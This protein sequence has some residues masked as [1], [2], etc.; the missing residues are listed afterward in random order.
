MSALHSL[1]E[2]FAAAVFAASPVDDLLDSVD[3]R[4]PVKANAG[5]G[6]YRRSVI[7]NLAAAVKTSYPVVGAIVGEEFMTAACRRYAQAFPSTSGDLNLYGGDFASFLAEF[8]PANALPYLTDVASLEWL[9]QAV[10]G[11]A[12]APAQDLRHLAETPPEEW[13][14]IKFVTDPAH[15]VYTSRCP[16][17]RIWEIHQPGYTGD[18]DVD[19]SRAQTALVH[20]RSGLIHVS[21]ISA[22]ESIFLR[23]LSALSTLDQSTRTACEADESFALSDALMRFIADGLLRQVL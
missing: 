5:L 1:Q 19:F 3:T 10:S 11:A 2:R 20:R 6:A 13:G 14:T 23:E 16:V 9:V 12:D 17:V 8:P 4:D 18:F 7:A 22:A 21:E 15:D